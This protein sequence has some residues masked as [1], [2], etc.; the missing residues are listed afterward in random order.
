[1]T[2]VVTLFV[3]GVLLVALEI[4]APGAI[5]GIVGGICLLGGVIAAFVQLGGTGGAI[6][7]GVAL[8]IG[9]VT[10]Y[11]EFVILPKSRLAKK[12][13]MIETVSSRSQPEVADRAVVVGREVVA[14]TTLA[15]S[16]YV[17]LEGRRY[18]AFCQSGMVDA[19]ARLR[20][21]DVDAFR[22]VVN[23]IKETS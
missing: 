3:A 16:G 12:F 2:L 8:A 19:G 5:L 18:E 11:L 21:V 9:M 14:V 7:S 6:A 15:P 22:L 13:S 10:L 23:Q 20:I 1:M 17:E 4:V